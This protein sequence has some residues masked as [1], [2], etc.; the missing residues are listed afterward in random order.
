VVATAFAVVGGSQLP[1]LAD[2]TVTVHGTAFPDLREAQLTLVGCESLY[3]RSTEFLQ[4]YISRHTRLGTRSLKYDLAGGNA[5]G[6]LS[7]VDSMTETSVAGLQV[8]SRPGAQGV[9]YAGY[10]SPDAE[11][12]DLWVGRASLMSNGGW[13]SMG[14]TTLTYTWE[15][16]DMRTGRPTGESADAPAT[17]PDF[18]EGHG[19]DGAGFYMVGFGCDGAPFYMDGWQVG[20]PGTTTTYDLEALTTHLTMNGTAHAIDA[21]DEVTINGSVR[22]G[23][24][25][26][27]RAGTMILEAKPV[28]GGSFLPV[29]VVDA[30]ATDPSITV[31]PTESTVYRWR[32]VDRPLATAS[33]SEQFRVDVAEAE[34]EG[35]PEKNTPPERN[36]TPDAPQS[37]EPAEEPT[38]EPS[39][40]TPP[41]VT[42]T[43]EPT[44]AATPDATTE[45]SSTP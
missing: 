20:A 11:G 41:P 33:V 5:I 17:V 39:T 14:A 37:T 25:R 36:R 24:D 15:Q 45:P 26:R 6:T 35:E 4:P 38:E 27:L 32:F 3:E 23:S 31:A 7:Y 42:T 18:A 10:Q 9:A 43:P 22:D 1:A 13:Q 2:D 8:Y 29:Q 28:G 34:G 21:G 30:A 16:F 40:P 12:Y 44:P 19:G